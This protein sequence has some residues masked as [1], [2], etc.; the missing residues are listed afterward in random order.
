[1]TKV[2]VRTLLASTA[3]GVVTLFAGLSTPATTQAAPGQIVTG[4]RL[5]EWSAH[6]WSTADS[7]QGDNALELLQSLP[8]EFDDPA[9]VEFGRAIDQYRRNIESREKMRDERIAESE[10]TLA[11]YP[12]ETA[13]NDA[14][15]SVVEL[16][17]FSINKAAVLDEPAVRRVLNDAEEAAKRHEEAGEWLDAHGLYNRAGNDRT[18]TNTGPAR[19]DAGRP[20]RAGDSRRRSRAVVA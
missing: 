10:A 2:S 7:G 11:A 19:S 9:L 20:R 15:M 18:R 16:Y 1:M 4:D 13:L 6:L 14:L 5:A 12:A 8:S 17:E 3:L